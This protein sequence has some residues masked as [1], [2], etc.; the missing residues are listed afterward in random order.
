MLNDHLDLLSRNAKEELKK[1]SLILSTRKEFLQKGLSGIQIIDYMEKNEHFVSVLHASDEY[2]VTVKMNS[3]APLYFLTVKNMRINGIA[4]NW[5]FIKMK[6]RIWSMERDTLKDIFIDQDLFLFTEL[7][8]F[9]RKFE[10]QNIFC[11]GKFATILGRRLFQKQKRTKKDKIGNLVIIDRTIDLSTP[12][13][14]NIEYKHIEKQMMNILLSNINE[15]DKLNTLLDLYLVSLQ[16]DA[17]ILQIKREMV[18]TF[19]EKM[20][21]IFDLIEKLF[22]INRNDYIYIPDLCKAVIK[23]DIEKLKFDFMQNNHEN[24]VEENAVL[25]IGGVCQKELQDLKHFTV[26]TTKVV[27]DSFLRELLPEL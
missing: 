20:V 21:I 19:G 8:Y 5:Y 11:K 3:E 4:L 22:Q 15:Y 16:L 12:L 23:K 27:N 25:F 18:Y 1:Y 13:S 9:F 6:N 7:D 10:I 2:H 17:E 24:S 14:L 26:L